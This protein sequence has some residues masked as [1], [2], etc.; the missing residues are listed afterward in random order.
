MRGAKQKEMLRFEKGDSSSKVRLSVFPPGGGGDIFIRAI[1]IG[2][3]GG[4][5]PNNLHK[6]APPPK[7]KKKNKKIKI[8]KFMCAP[9]ICNV[10]PPPP[11]Q[12]VI[13]SYGPVHT[14]IGSGYFLGVQNFEFQYFWVFQ[15]TEYFCGY[16]DFVDI[17]GGSSQ[18]WTILYIL[19][20]F[21][22]V[23]LQNVGYFLGC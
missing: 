4:V 1:G 21:L 15:K 9:P 19:G 11:P 8:K 6:Y 22:K 3:G 18:N 7:K 10:C 14:Y 16:E 23:K 13:A 17:F 20:S 12:S 5:P 2:V